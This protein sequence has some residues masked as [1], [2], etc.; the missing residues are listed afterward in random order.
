MFV[1]SAMKRHKIS[2]HI[3]AICVIWGIYSHGMYMGK[4]KQP[5][6]NILVQFNNILSKTSI[7][8]YAFNK[9]FELDTAGQQTEIVNV[10]VITIVYVKIN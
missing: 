7:F 5:S 10:T 8:K 1:N 6:E 9:Y 2:I 3:L 4:K